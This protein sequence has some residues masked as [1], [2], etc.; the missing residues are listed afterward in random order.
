MPKRIFR[1]IA[2]VFTLVAVT[3]I[4]AL[5]GLPSGKL[6]LIFLDVGQGDAILIST[7]DNHKVLIDAGPAGAILDPL[8]QELNFWE[9]QIDLVILTHPDTDHI[10]GFVEVLKRYKI[11]QVLLTGV[12]HETEW[13]AEILRQIAEQGITTTVANAATDFDLG[14]GVLLDVFWPEENLAGRFVSDAN[15]ASVS[16]K[17]IFGT[18]SAI[19]TGDLDI[20]SEKI[21]L[22][23]SPDLHAQILKLGHHGSKTSSSQEF[24][25]AV[26]PSYAVVSASADNS[27][28]HPSPEVLAKL[29][30]AKILETSKIGNIRFISDGQT[31]RTKN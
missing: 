12:Q 13:Y 26:S 9:R 10:A 5:S 14:G 29:P 6:E 17:L 7:P 23:S 24:L 20:E 18:T 1:K 2:L 25:A 15:A 3:A 31:W 11:G 28:G 8:A 30:D 16:A 19:L 22:E 21:I 4:I 27:F